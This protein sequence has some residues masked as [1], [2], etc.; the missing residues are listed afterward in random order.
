MQL[1]SRDLKH[2][3]KEIKV[4][5]WIM[6]ATLIM[7]LATRFMTMSYMSHIEK[8]ITTNESAKIGINKIINLYELNPMIKLLVNLKQIGYILLYFLIPA[9]AFSVYLFFRR[10][11]L[12]GRLDIEVLQHFVIFAFFVMLF[13]IVNDLGALV[14]KWI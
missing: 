3:K 7:I 14:G 9:T 8:E 11:V 5:D 10:R 2:T 12:R 1:K 6:F 13:N 4:C